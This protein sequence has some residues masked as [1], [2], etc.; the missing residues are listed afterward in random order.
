MFD[1]GE[2]LSE[3]G[4]VGWSFLEDGQVCAEWEARQE[5]IPG[6]KTNITSIGDVCPQKKVLIDEWESS[7]R[8]DHWV[9]IL[10]AKYILDIMVNPQPSFPIG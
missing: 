7:R 2:V 4:I 1:V 3:G 10:N 9:E 5:D 6:R 8:L